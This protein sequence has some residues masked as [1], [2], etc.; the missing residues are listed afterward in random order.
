MWKNQEETV[1]LKN[2]RESKNLV[3]G[4]N[5][6]W[7]TSEERISELEDRSIENTQIE[8]QKKEKIQKS[9][10]NKWDMGNVYLT[11]LLLGFQRRGNMNNELIF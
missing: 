11:N 6:R 9:L 7:D 5:N 3:D 8:K 10:R 2:L 1:E 4:F